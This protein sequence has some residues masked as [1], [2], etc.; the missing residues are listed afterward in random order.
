ML[1]QHA[2]GSLD[3]KAQHYLQT[4]TDAATRMGRLIDDLLTFSRM[5]RAAL[6][7]RP[8]DLADLVR[9]ARAEVATE[10]E[11]RA[12]QW[13]V[14]PLPP[15]VV[16]PALMRPALVNLLSNAVKY[17]GTREDARI[18]IGTTP[19]DGGEV[20]VFVR[21]NGVGFDMQY[22]D[23][24]FGVFQR[25]HRADEFSGTGIGLANV[26][27]IIQRHGG[28]T[29]A[30]AEVGRGA[31]FFFSLPAGAVNDGGSQTYPAR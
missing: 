21:D 2:G 10:V 7:P 23:K 8:I 6:A 30:E 27:R 5:G 28:R 1:K 29:W 12:I 20:V 13:H 16:D 31:T 18:E 25:L 19:S 26:R 11:G 17:T 9:E 24:L 14:Q 15:V 4:M 3:A 22:A